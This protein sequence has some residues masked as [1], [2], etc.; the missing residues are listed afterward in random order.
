MG[1][2]MN[3]LPVTAVGVGADFPID[4]YSRCVE[5]F[6]YEAGWAETMIMVVRTCGKAIVYTGLTLILSIIPW[7]FISALKFQAQMGFVLSMLL[8]ADVILAMMLHA[9]MIYGIKPGFIKRRA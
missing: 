4:P 3:T 7:Y 9:V 2:S 8:L 5:E 1:L 6:T